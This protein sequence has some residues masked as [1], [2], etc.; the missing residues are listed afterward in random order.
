[1]KPVRELR[2]EIAEHVAG[3]REAVQQE[4]RWRLLRPGLAVENADA[5][6]IQ[7][8]VRDQAH[9]KCFALLTG[10]FQGEYRRLKYYYR[11]WRV[12][13]MQLTR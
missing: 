11:S 8:L 2:D 13:R 10:L 7:L 3:G 6:N 4:D 9:E 1:M 5:A 12:D